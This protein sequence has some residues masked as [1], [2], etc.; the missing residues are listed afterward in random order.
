MLAPV[1][2]PFPG[3]AFACCFALLMLFGMIRFLRTAYRRRFDDGPDNWVPHAALAGGFFLFLVLLSWGV[4]R[5]RSH[6]KA[7]DVQEQE[8]GFTEEVVN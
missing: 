4:W 8:A 5:N 2:Y 6:F 3:K 7:P 1:G